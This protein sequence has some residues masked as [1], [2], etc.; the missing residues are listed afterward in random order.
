M[1]LFFMRH[2][3]ASFDAATDAERP[4]T[5]LG[6]QQSA[7]MVQ[8]LTQLDDFDMIFVS[9]YLRAQQTLASLN[10]PAHIK[11]TSLDELTPESDPTQTA[12][13]LNAY[14]EHFKMK[15]A[16]VIAHMPL[17]GYLMSEY[18]PGLE[19]LL[20]TTSGI[21]HISYNNDQVH[22]QMYTPQ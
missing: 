3:Q 1:N 4:L 5:S 19:P 17:L 18:V 7:D 10:L 9:P 2:G 14:I 6:R 16:L 12:I 21:A 13:T 22:W 15:K 8:Y 20:F 11:V